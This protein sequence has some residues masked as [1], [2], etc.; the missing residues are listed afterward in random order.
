V[1][2]KG[3]NNNNEGEVSNNK[4]TAENIAK[5]LDSEQRQF[6]AKIEKQK[7]EAEKKLY[8]VIIPTKIVLELKR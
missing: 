4:I 5:Q 7:Q 3:G 6:L 2:G 1:K 8:Q